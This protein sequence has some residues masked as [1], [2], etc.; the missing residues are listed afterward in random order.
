MT[1]ASV[2]LTVGI[3][4]QGDVLTTDALLSL[5]D[6][7]PRVTFGHRW[8]DPGQ[9]AEVIVAEQRSDG[10]LWL[11]VDIPL[12]TFRAIVDR[13]GGYTDEH[14][15]WGMAY[16]VGRALRFS[17]T[18]VK[19]RRIYETITLRSIDATPMPAPTA[20]PSSAR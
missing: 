12:R 14:V 2:R 4:M 20:I 3:K 19:Q 10:R 6:D 13:F 1:E 15:Y 7:R 9:R 17:D 8:D 5:I 16:Q 18:D 11:T